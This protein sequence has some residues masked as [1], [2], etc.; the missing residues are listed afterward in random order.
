MRPGLGENRVRIN[1]TIHQWR[2]IY[3]AFASLGRE[4]EGELLALWFDKLTTI[5]EASPQTGEDTSVRP[6]ILNLIDQ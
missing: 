5:G 3:E 6:C 2:P 1:L 4:L